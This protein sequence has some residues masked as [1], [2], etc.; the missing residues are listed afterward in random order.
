MTTEPEAETTA[1]E[2]GTVG[3]G[4]HGESAINVVKF[5]GM[6][7]VDVRKIWLK[8]V[9]WSLKGPQFDLAATAVQ[10]RPM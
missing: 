8:A 1:R 9:V 5:C 3:A 6:L 7:A 10:L 4:P 2:P